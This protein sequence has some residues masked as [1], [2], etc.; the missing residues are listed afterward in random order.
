MHRLGLYHLAHILMHSPPIP[1]PIEVKLIPLQHLLPLIVPLLTGVSSL[2]I[3]TDTYIVSRHVEP[4]LKR[5]SGHRGSR[6]TGIVLA[7]QG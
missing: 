6:G 4:G 7:S 5:Y 2:V 1:I 3:H